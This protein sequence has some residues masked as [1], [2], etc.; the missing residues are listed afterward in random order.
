MLA[1]GVV[2][3]PN[4]GKSTFFAAATLANVAIAN[5]PFT[6]I[7]ANRG[8]AY[9]R[10]PCPHTDLGRPCNPQNSACDGGTRLIPVELIDVAGLVRGAHEGR[11]R[12]NQFLDDLRQAAVLIHVVDAAGA[13]DAEGSP[14][15]PGTHDPAE[16]VAFLEEE[17]HHWMAGILEKG[18]ERTARLLDQ[19]GRKIEELI[20]ERVAG[21]GISRGQ[22][23]AALREH[24][25]PAKASAW[26]GDDFM[27]VAQALQRL[28]KPILI[29]A[30]KCDLADR[31]AVERIDE[32]AGGEVFPTAAE[33]ELALRRADRAGVVR[34]ALGAGSFEVLKAEALSAAQVAGL[35]KIRA[36]LGAWGSTGVQRVLEHAVF[37]RLR[38]IPVYPVEDEGKWTD[39]DG[40]VLP[41]A[42]L[43]PEGATARDLAFKVHTDLGEHFIRAID[44][45]ARRVVGADH[46]L[47][48]GDVVK[49][50]AGK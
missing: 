8:V 14:V 23:M 22:A 21:L 30:N 48:A 27:A 12:G 42:H 36:F 47:K 29:A 9:V 4:V 17:V 11:G 25:P 34:Y 3:K 20:H 40:N 1:A 45:R 24:P 18:W 38:L 41:H 26:K 32:A 50:V 37:E 7:D 15:A 16:D 35:E 43:V 28:G 49:I 44:A 39:K 31:E 10:A 5:F 6:T 19:E 2:G 46:A 33:M 13:T